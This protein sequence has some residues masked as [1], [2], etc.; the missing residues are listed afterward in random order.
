MDFSRPSA[1]DVFEMAAFSK[2]LELMT[3]GTSGT[4][5]IWWPR[6][7]R[8]AGT[9]EAAR[10][11]TVAKRLEGVVSTVS[12]MKNDNLDVLL[13]QV[14]LLVPLSPDLCRGEHATRAAHVTKGSLSSTVSSSSRDTRDTGDGATCRVSY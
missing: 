3:R 11:E 7:R 9:D 8:R 14:D 13:A 4:L 10:A 6:A 5:E 12:C 2:T 1:A